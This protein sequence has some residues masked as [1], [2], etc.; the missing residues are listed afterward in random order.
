MTI[1]MRCF[2]KFDLNTLV[3]FLVV[4]QEQGV[5]RA[6]KVL[7][8][9]QPAV[10]NVLS[11]LRVR[12]DDPLFIPSGRRLRPT[13]KAESIARELAPAMVALSA[14]VAST[15]ACRPPLAHLLDRCPP[16]MED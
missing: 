5:S 1:D 9:T 6:A 2:H 4:Y 15:A 13:L 12:F 7:N 8:V 14:L 3:T 16:P 10:S 11:K